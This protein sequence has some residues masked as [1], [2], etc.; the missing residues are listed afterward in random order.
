MD[1]GLLVVLEVL[2][3]RELKVGVLF[4]KGLLVVNGGRRGEGEREH[5]DR[6]MS[7]VKSCVGTFFFF[8]S[9]SFPLRS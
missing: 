1:S 8:S 5:G 3:D 7:D 6:T 4:T 2:P 9:T